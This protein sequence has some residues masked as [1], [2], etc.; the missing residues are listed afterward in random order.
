MQ[1]KLQ[2]AKELL[3]SSNMQIK[4]IG[5]F[6]NFESESYFITFFKNKAGFTPA[7]YRSMCMASKER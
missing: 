4:E 6:L 7:H 2:K 1:V 3:T 5:A